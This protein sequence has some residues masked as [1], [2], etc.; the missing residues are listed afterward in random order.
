MKKFFAIAFIAAALVACNN[1]AE[2]KTEKKDSTVIETPPP[3]PIDTTRTDTLV[4]VP[5]TTKK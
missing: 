4:V 1:D 3:A 5:D 2:T